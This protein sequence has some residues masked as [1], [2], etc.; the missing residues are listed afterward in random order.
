MDTVYEATIRGL[1]YRHDI[2]C[3]ERSHG[4]NLQRHSLCKN[5]SLRPIRKKKKRAH[6]D[7]RGTYCVEHI[8]TLTPSQSIYINSL[9]P[10]NLSTRDSL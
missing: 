2:R 3:N 9:V 5:G 4:F 8:F 7:E 1:G 10:L 6:R